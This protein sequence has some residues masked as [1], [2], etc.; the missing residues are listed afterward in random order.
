MTEEEVKLNFGD[1]DK[2]VLHFYA[3]YDAFSRFMD[4]QV[5]GDFGFKLDAA[6]KPAAYRQY[7]G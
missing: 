2:P 3:L 5:N 4:Y 1:V 6:I 7:A